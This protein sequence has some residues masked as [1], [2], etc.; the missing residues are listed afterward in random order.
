MGQRGDSVTAEDINEASFPL[1]IGPLYS[2]PIVYKPTDLQ[3]N[4][5][6]W[7]DEVLRPAV[8]RLVAMANTDIAQGAATGVNYYTGDPSSF[9]NSFAS[10]NQA[11]P[12][13]DNLNANGYD[14]YICL[15]PKNAEQLM[16]AN[17]LQ[18]SFVSPINK[19]ITYDAKVGRLA[20]FDIMKDNSISQQV[21]GTHAASG[22]ITVNAA[23]SSGTT[24]VLAGLTTSATFKAGDKF[25]IAGVKQFDRINRVPLATDM[26]FT[27]AADATAAGATLSITITQALVNSGPR[28][29]F[30][31]VGASP[32]Q[33]P[34]NA[35]V[36]FTSSYTPNVAYTERG[37]ITVI[38]PLEKMDSPESS[39][40]TDTEWGVSMR[41]SKSADVLNNQNI[42]RLDMQMAFAWVP[43]QAVILQ[44]L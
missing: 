7:G 36:T 16:N 43:D 37:L 13:L 8:R 23:V 4:I 12:V 40:F 22:N 9:L 11:N 21:A 38:P 24:I 41:V 42:F 14:R 25:S 3:R 29:N 33:I 18:N 26:Q 17:S 1:T 28:Q 19:D 10:I 39:V 31:V 15:S 27:V 6:D 20:G 2:I 5:V 35:V 44:S 32:N 30:I 34:A